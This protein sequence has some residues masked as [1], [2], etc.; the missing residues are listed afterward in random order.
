MEFKPVTPEDAS[1]V[2]LVREAGPGLEVYMTR[3]QESL[4]FLGG[5]HV[6][7]GGKMDPADRSPE[8]MA[9]CKGLAPEAASAR[10]EGVEQPAM[11]V[12]LMVA[13]IRELFEE[14]GVL[15][16]EYEDGTRL[17]R[18]SAELCA[19]LSEYRE[20]LQADRIS[21]AQLLE[22]ESLF[23]SIA[24][25]HWF[26]HWITPATSPRRFS[27]YFFTARLPEGQKASPFASE[28]AEALWVRPEQAIA[29]WREGRW[30]MIPPTI[31]SLDTL[32]R[33]R[34]WDELKRDFSR[35]PEEHRRT[36][37]KEL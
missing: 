15:L 4:M 16:A 3:R 23:C 20:K 37:W 22:A 21:L 10:I 17:T 33:Y 26:A 14:A 9:R 11:A 30:K 8:S 29:N 32:A 27:T 24:H 28:I 5:F 13:A 12:G 25:I 31:A 2:I 1:T 6:F 36:V 34:S 18:P 19:R 35:A 7:P